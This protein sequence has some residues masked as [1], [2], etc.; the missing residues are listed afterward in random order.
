MKKNNIILPFLFI[1]FF[2][3]LEGKS[4]PDSIY[5]V[6]K[7]YI[8]DAQKKNYT[9]L[10]DILKIIPDI[11]I[12]DYG[13][14]G[15]LS[16]CRIRGCQPNQIL[17][18]IDGSPISESWSG[19]VDLNL[20]PVEIIKQI[21]VFPTSNPYG[22]NSIG[23]LINIVT[24]DYNLIRPYTKIVYRSGSYN[25][26]DLDI[27]FG[28][29]ISTKLK[30][31]SALQ[32][33]K[34]GS[35]L[36]NQ[37]YSTEKFRTNI[38]YLIN[39]TWDLKSSILFNKSEIEI[40]HIINLPEDSLGI[41][42]PNL[43]FQRYDHSFSIKGKLC[44]IQ[45]FFNAYYTSVL[46]EFPDDNTNTSKKIASHTT[47]LLVRQK[48]PS[49]IIP[50]SWGITATHPI[51]KTISDTLFKKLTMQSYFQIGYKFTDHLFTTLQVQ[52][53]IT[54]DNKFRLFGNSQIVYKIKPDLDLWI[55][56]NQSIREPTL[57]ESYG[58]MLYQSIP[59]I[60]EQLHIKNHSL[61]FLS[62]TSLKPE[63]SQSIEIGSSWRYKSII[64]NTICLYYKKTKD[65]IQGDIL[66]ENAR[67][68][69]LSDN[70]FYGIETQVLFGPIYG[71]KLNLIFNFLN[72]F[73]EKNNTLFERPNYWGTGI[74]SWEY[75]LF[76]NDLIINVTISNRYNS[77]FWNLYGATLDESENILSGFISAF[78][79]KTS[80][81]IMKYATIAFSIDNFLNA[82]IQNIYGF[83]APKTNTRLSICWELFD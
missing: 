31:I 60:P 75:S 70:H 63:I 43:K 10:G 56:Y 54:S 3:R 17:F 69:N 14:P 67:F 24:K 42:N 12:R 83:S 16:S 25:F 65:L 51:F 66:E 77:G 78:N 23:G 1:L 32:L 4:F 34:S 20:I 79:F 62:N 18:L 11:W 38:S 40:P 64:K 49:E 71:F 19:I 81:T 36:N 37:N 9:Y 45:T 48:I 82:D 2:T 55:G 27:T 47:S 53:H 6:N 74:F 22:F 76:Q 61:N 68:I 8:S 5:N 50:A 41:I 58:Y 7:I 44:N 80:L 21:E 73:D 13:F 59:V 35:D 26:S 33:N 46:Y 15:Q 29:T 57:G 72:A 30:F 28:Q 39:N 52:T